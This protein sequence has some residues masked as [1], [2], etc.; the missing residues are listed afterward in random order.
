M[1]VLA[2][3]PHPD[4]ETLGCGGTLLKHRANGD[5]IYWL[6]ATRM[7]E[8]NGFAE[9]VIQTRNEEIQLIS[10]LYGFRGVYQLDYPT[11][12]LDEI[13]TADLVGS[14]SAV[15]KEIKPE[16]IYLPFRDDVHTDH[17][18][19]FDAA[20][21]CTKWFRYPYIRKVFAYETLSET[22]FGLNPSSNGFRPNYFVNISEYL[23]LKQSIME[24]YK[25]EIS[26][27]P[28]P[29]SKMGIEAL[30]RYRG[31]ASNC[32]AAEAFM[33]LKEIVE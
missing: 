29:R 17:K 25:S 28:F 2:V 6:I 3:A 5:D 26:E 15:I 16:V 9:D 10:N 22:E 11:M 21:S 8:R 18:Y 14:F 4:D 1:K 13:P 30:A 19:V 27:F 23:P 31:L 24:S 12:R 32:E 7:S 33:L 20:A